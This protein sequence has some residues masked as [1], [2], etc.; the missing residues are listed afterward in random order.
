MLRL[1]AEAVT[2]EELEYYLNNLGS[3]PPAEQDAA[4]E[5]L[6]RLTGR[7]PDQDCRDRFLPFV[8]RVWPEFIHGR[9]HD[10]MAD[11]FERIEAGKLK[12]CI[13]NM[14]PR[15]TKSK[16][17]SVLFPGW[18]LGKN[19]RRK[20]LAGSHSVGLAMD[21][22][23]D[24]RNL[25]IE[26]AYQ[27]LFKGVTLS[28]DSRAAHRWSTKQG[29]E[30]FAVGKTGGAAGKGGDLV[31]ID[32]PHSEQDVLRNPKAEFEKTWKWYLA[33]P[34]QRLQPGAAILVVMT[35]WGE[36]DLTGRLIKAYQ[37]LE[38]ELEPWEV[39]ELPAIMP[40]GE[41]V[42]PEFW[43]IEELRATR[44]IMPATR[45]MANYQQQPI[46][47][48][49]AI[50]KREWWKN[51]TDPNPPLCDFIVQS[52]DTA[53]SEKDTACRSACITWGVFRSRTHDDPPRL[54]TGIILLDAWA[55]RVG[56]PELKR[57][58]RDL[59]DQ[60]K[61]DSLVIERKSAGEPLIQELFRAGIY[62]S[63]AGV[64][65][66]R[67][68]DKVMRTNAV[69][70]LFSSGAVY[71]PLGHRWV[72][73]VRDEMGAFP[74]GEFDDL[75]DAAVWGLLRIRQ[76]N[77]IHLGTDEEDLEEWKPRPPTQYY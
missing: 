62:V 5:Q 28:Q 17:A 71:A 10:V 67:S 1:V 26:D 58:A 6:L 41:P 15:S 32:D 75:H 60:W 24:L 52:W 51:W 8:R 46:S 2:N 76:G 14:P 27:G 25:V 68:S 39:I 56:F 70:D 16:F 48:E 18:Y 4:R 65:P 73:Q 33:G 36:M 13:I 49:G 44:A 20:I 22:G 11:A 3:L 29:G 74:L 38:E 21:F 47:E 77:L 31:V 54:Y 43:S 63:D 57:K 59:F 64:T 37:E 45:W 35:R 72:E 53:H 12:R 23:R 40:S 55:A 66:G 50:I 69:A 7:D 34:R 9:H 19:P 42:F 30:Y 61:P